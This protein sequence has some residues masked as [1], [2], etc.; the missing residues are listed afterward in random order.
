MP[1]WLAPANTLQA[2]KSYG[3]LAPQPESQHTPSV[4]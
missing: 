1:F 4:Q 2:W 3:S